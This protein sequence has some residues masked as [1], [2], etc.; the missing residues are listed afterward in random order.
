MGSGFTLLFP[1]HWAEQRLLEEG[2]ADQTVNTVEIEAQR[3]EAL[4]F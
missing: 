4:P 1:D 3:N 2:A